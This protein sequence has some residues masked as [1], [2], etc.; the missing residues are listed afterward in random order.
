MNVIYHKR[1]VIAAFRS[2]RMNR[3]GALLIGLMLISF[4][5]QAQSNVLDSAR[6]WVSRQS[7]DLYSSQSLS[8]T[9]YVTLNNTLLTLT[10]H[11]VARNFPVSNVEGSWSDINQPGQLTFDVVVLGVTGKGKVQNESGV[12]SLTID[13]S[14]RKDWMKRKFVLTH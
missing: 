10:T 6:S 2:M 5:S 8:D 1:Q 12:L 4:F 7:V 13:L 11:N 14:E 9:V 3:N